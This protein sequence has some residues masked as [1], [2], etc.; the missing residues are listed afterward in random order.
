[1]AV[2]A[3]APAVVAFALVVYTAVVHRWDLAVFWLVAAF[4]LRW[5]S[6]Q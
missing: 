5:E 4:Y 6:E 1:M 2:I 3:A